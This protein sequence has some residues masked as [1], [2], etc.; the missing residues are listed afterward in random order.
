[1]LGKNNFVGNFC[2]AACACVFFFFDKFCFARCAHTQ[3]SS[4]SRNK[5]HHYKTKQNLLD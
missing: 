5:H 3:F 2:F 1:M 4:I